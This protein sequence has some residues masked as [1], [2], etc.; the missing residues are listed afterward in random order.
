MTTE[1]KAK[2]YD[3]A[4][5]RAEGLINF[6]SDSELKTLEYVF[7]ELKKSEDE[8]IRKAIIEGL[9]EMKS[10]FH[11]ISSIKIDDAIAWLEKQ[12]E[13]AN[14]R[15]KIQVGDK[16]TRN[17]DG[18]LVNLSQLKR[19]AKPSK[20]QGEKKP[21]K[22]TEEDAMLAEFEKQGEQKTVVTIPKFRI[23]DS[24]KTTNEEPLTI[25]KIDGKGYWSED[26]LICNFDD[27]AKW[28]LVEQKPVWSEE[29]NKWIESLIQTFE[30]GYFEGFNQLKSYGVIDWLKSLKERIRG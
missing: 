16:V 22:W 15:N 4:T 13:Y 27:A 1:E 20:E 26:L 6:C 9:R 19:V 12:G 5:E 8:R 18:V 11:T 23:G 24:I 21:T 29:D 14:F 2:A 3:E 30:D 7:P 17:R 10:I 28:E 25:T